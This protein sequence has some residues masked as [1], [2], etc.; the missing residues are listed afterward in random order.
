MR[1][2][3]EAES[4]PWQK[5]WDRSSVCCAVCYTVC[6]MYAVLCC[7]MLYVLCG[8]CLFAVSLI[9]GS[10]SYSVI[11]FNYQ[12]PAYVALVANSCHS[13]D[14]LMFALSISFA[15]GQKSPFPSQPC[16]YFCTS[17]SLCFLLPRLPA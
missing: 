4:Q 2:S 11:Q 7:V 14:Q 13:Q 17:N 16:T 9:Q 12:L 15:P 10:E 5:L 3:G 1:K 8:L 6:V